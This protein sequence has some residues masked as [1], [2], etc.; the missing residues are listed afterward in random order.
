MNIKN[1]ITDKKMVNKNFFFIKIILPK[2]RQ[3]GDFLS[4]L[5]GMDNIRTCLI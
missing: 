4:I 1:K 5:Q 2:N 3:N